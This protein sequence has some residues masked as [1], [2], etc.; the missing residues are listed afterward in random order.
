[1]LLITGVTGLTGRFMVNALREAGYSGNIRCLIREHSDISWVT[2]N[3]VE[4]VKGDVTDVQSLIR[5]FEGIEGVIHLVNIRSAPEIIE[6]CKVTGINRVVIVTTT[7]IFSKYQQYSEEYK[8]LETMIL[9]C[10][11]D[12]TIIRPTMIYGNHRDK[13]IHKL[14]KI[15]NKYPIVPVIGNG[16]GLMQPIFAKDLAGVISAA[17]TNPVSIKKAYNVAGKNPISLKDIMCIIA[18][19]LNK[20]RLFFNLPYSLALVGGYI[21]EII[22]NGLINI[23]RIQ[24][25]QEDKVFSYDEAA[26]DLGFSPVSFN[27]GI[28]LE[29]GTLKQ[30]GII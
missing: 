28:K 7:G 5:V 27:E 22:P 3:N 20:K 13:N 1:M 19:N 16:Y 15:V 25:L 17:Y 11:L 14:V 12:Y 21:G 2:D 23:E 26:K 6:A 9:G 30:S 10:G 8:K 4:F 24:R 29:I 18:K